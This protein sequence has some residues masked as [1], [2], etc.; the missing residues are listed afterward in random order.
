MVA[1]T[2]SKIGTYPQ[3]VW[4]GSPRC[5]SS[6][7]LDGFPKSVA[8]SWSAWFA[9]PHSTSC[10]PEAFWG[11]WSLP[12][13]CS[14]SRDLHTSHP[15]IGP[16]AWRLATRQLRAK[17]WSPSLGVSQQSYWALTQYTRLPRTQEAKKD[18]SQGTGPRV[19][20]WGCIRTLKLG[21]K[22]GKGEPSRNGAPQHSHIGPLL[23]SSSPSRIACLS[24][25]L[26]ASCHT[27]HP[28]LGF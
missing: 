21:G 12:A 4:Q 15:R 23:G 22:I 3:S 18:S 7:L 8:P 2:T 11:L 25:F 10:W 6:S 17:G 19:R 28:T 20:G 9:L 27:G 24:I 14:S 16:R 26:V 13:I 5:L 1:S